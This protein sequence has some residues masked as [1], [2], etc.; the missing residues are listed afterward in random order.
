M[1]KKTFLIL[2]SAFLLSA[3]SLSALTGKEIMQ[4]ASDSNEAD[5]THSLVDLKLI[6]KSNSMSTRIIEMFGK[7]NSK[8][9]SL[10]LIIF[11]S[12]ASVKNTRFLSL[13][14]KGRG[15]DQWIYL[16]ALKKVRRIAAGEGN[17][18][19]M[20]TDLTYDDMGSRNIED[21]THKLAGENK[22]NGRACYVVE[23]IPRNGTKSQYSKRI[24]FV[25]K[26]RMIP[27]KMELFDKE[28]KLLKIMVMGDIKNI[29]GHWTPLSTSMENVQEKHKTIITITKIVYDEKLP[30]GIFTTRFLQSGRL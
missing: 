6:D 16:P 8:D 5:S 19:F 7:K 25:D 23:S 15:S 24:S 28:G 9:E 10:S 14:N 27:L 1:I 18:S 20:G 17:K 26:E 29:Q 21:D 22:V 13:E 30:D 12:P 3:A 2:I 11:H 4:E